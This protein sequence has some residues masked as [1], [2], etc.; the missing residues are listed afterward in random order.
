[1]FS[2]ET[3]TRLQ[4]RIV[5]GSANNQLLDIDAAKAL[6]E[7]GILYAPHYVVNAGGVINISFEIGRPYEETAAR[8]KTLAI[9]DT[10]QSVIA[11]AK[12]RDITTAKAADRLAEKRIEQMRQMRQIRRIHA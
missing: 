8:E 9:Y 7:R 11:T 6:K 3:V 4:S 10:M 5:C 2:T 1:V 12:D